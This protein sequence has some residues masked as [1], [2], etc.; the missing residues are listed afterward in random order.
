ML[1]H[2]NKRESNSTPLNLSFDCFSP[3]LTI[4]KAGFYGYFLIFVTLKYY[5]NGS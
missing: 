1:V 5:N 3:S 2:E 4:M